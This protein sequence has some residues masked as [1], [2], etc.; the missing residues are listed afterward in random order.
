MN[1][2][3]WNPVFATPPHPDYPSGHSTVAGA[4][5]VAFSNLFGPNY[6]FT[7]HTYDYLGLPARTYNSFANMAEEIGKSRVYAGIHYTYACEQGRL[8]GK[9]IAQNIESKLKF[10]K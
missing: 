2:P 5:E 6:S 4:A 7:N 8:Q 3:S 9:K 1:H 10:K